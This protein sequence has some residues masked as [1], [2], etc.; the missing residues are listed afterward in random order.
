MKKFGIG[1]KIWISMGALCAGYLLLLVLTEW[2]GHETDAHLKTT[3]ESLFPAALKSQEA[4]A[5]FQRLV[6]R[7]SDA[8]LLQDK[9]SLAE[10]DKEAQSVLAALRSISNSADL[11]PERR[12]EVKQVL[13]SFPDLAD[14]STRTYSAMIAAG[15]NLPADLQSSAMRLASNN[16]TIEAAL[17]ALQEN[18]SADFRAEFSAVKAVTTLQLRIESVLFGLI[19]L[20]V[21]PIIFMTVRQMNRALTQVTS[22]LAQTAEQMANAA[23]QASSASQSMAGQ[24]SE[25]AAS[26]E[27]T[28]AA[29]EEITA[30]TRKNADSSKKAAEMMRTVDDQVKDGNRAIDH[31][32]SSM[33]EIK[34]SSGKIKKIIKVIDE[35]AFQTNILALNAAV[36]AARA[37]E[38]GMSF[39]VVAEE[40]RN[41]AQ[42]SAQAAKDTAALIEESI[43]T[44]N[45]GNAKLTQVATVIGSITNSASE[46]KDLVDEVNAGSQEQAR[47]IQQ[48]AQSLAA[49]DQS[50]QNS[51]ANA[52]E[53]AAASEE[54]SA[55]AQSLNRIVDE[56]RSLVGGAISVR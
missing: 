17:R 13:T 51:A 42:R 23:N 43:A 53:S 35:I 50:T 4:E 55:H 29:S 40:V 10:A 32:K 45:G 36:E 14:R 1:A 28:A 21:A 6:K 16:K 20:V 9:G 15:A 27:E 18:I 8:V 31:M 22:S 7:Y 19:A 30:M 47:G 24:A 48:I 56:L 44:S 54:M 39:A 49:M 33:E 25:Q 52:E 12:D 46:V 5:A 34:S 11:L 3:A 38:A 37:G 2:F 26:L 41:L